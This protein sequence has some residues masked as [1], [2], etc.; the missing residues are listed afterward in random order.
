[1]KLTVIVSR[2]RPPSPTPSSS[3]AILLCGVII[4]SAI[5]SAGLSARPLAV[6]GYPD[7]SLAW[8]YI[9]PRLLDLENQGV[10]ISGISSSWLVVHFGLAL[11]IWALLLGIAISE[12]SVVALG[13]LCGPAI[14]LLV[15]S[16]AAAAALAFQLI[17]YFYPAALCGA[18]VVLADVPR[19]TL[20]LLALVVLMIGQR[21]PRFIG[22]VDRYALYQDKR[23]LFTA[24]EIDRLADQI[25]SLAVEIDVPDVL[26]GIL[27]LVEFGRRNLDLQWS[28]RTWTILFRY[29]GWPPQKL[30]EKARL[31]LRQIDPVIIDHF[32]LEHSP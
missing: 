9:W 12:R 29:R 26:P 1:M 20:P 21:S 28:D 17:G 14:M 6:A 11:T 18:C 16:I 19:Q 2:F 30:P 32:Q 3:Y 31:V 24:A 27:L 7:Y 23:F 25:G 5:I 22:A 13:L 15:L 10:A 8:I 4:A